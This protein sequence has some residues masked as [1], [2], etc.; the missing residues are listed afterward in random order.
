VSDLYLVGIGGH[1]GAGRS[2]LARRFRGAQVVGTDEFWNGSA[3]ELS[4]LERR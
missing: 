1:G 4:R 3:F 2:T